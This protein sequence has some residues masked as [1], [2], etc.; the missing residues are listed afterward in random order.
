M[1]PLVVCGIFFVGALGK[2]FKVMIFYD[3]G[4]SYGA[5]L[6]LFAFEQQ[7]IVLLV[8]KLRMICALCTKC[9]ATLH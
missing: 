9:F 8:M 3:K 7:I 1:R 2:T 5:V 6:T 4:N